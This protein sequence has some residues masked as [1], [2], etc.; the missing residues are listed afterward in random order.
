[1]HK[2]LG[3]GPRT[4]MQKAPE[5]GLPHALGREAVKSAIPTEPR[6]SRYAGQALQ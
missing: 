3:G 5:R 4:Q 2:A 1:M 6:R